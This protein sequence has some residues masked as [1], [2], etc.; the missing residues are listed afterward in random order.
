MTFA[1][2]DRGIDADLCF[3]SISAGP[4]N[5]CST[6]A[7][8]QVCFGKNRRG[9]ISTIQIELSSTI[10]DCCASIGEDFWISAFGI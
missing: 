10:L 8:T 5:K 1:V 6:A 7:Y 9:Q 3:W 4:G 2:I